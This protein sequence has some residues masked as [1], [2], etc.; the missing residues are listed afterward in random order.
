M[1]PITR[2]RQDYSCIAEPLKMKLLNRPTSHSASLLI[3]VRVPRRI[4]SNAT[5]GCLLCFAS[6]VRKP[7]KSSTGLP[8]QH[9][10][11]LRRRTRSGGALKQRKGRWRTASLAPS[12]EIH[13]TPSAVYV[14]LDQALL[15]FYGRTTLVLPNVH[16]I[17]HLTL[18]L[19]LHCRVR[20]LTS[21][22]RNIS[23]ELILN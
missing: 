20:G 7:R 11:I 2:A 9:C 8:N 18:H 12:L 23:G 10:P 3:N 19:I 6:P 17:L 15:L 5:S 22:R 14:Y 4:E 13:T 21:P 1:P 16:L